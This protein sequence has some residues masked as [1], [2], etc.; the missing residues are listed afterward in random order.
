MTVCTDELALLNL[1]QDTPT[2]MAVDE[3]PE[4]ISLVVPGR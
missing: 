3:P 1:L 2:A 4:I